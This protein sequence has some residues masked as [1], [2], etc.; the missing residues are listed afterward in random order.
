ML[1]FLRNELTNYG[2]FN[3]PNHIFVQSLIK[4]IP[5]N[6]VPEKMKTIFALSHLSQYASQF[7]RSIQLWD[8]TLVPTNNISFVIADSGANKD[9][10][11]NKI[12][13]CFADGY[14]QIGELVKDYVKNN[15]IEAAEK[16][17]EDSPYEYAI[18]KHYL[19]PIPPVFISITTAPGLIQHVNDIGAL[20]ALS[21]MQYSGEISDE[22]AHNPNALENIKVLAEVYDLGEKEATY[23][24][25]Q[26]FRSAEIKGQPV[27][28]LFVGSPG[29]I[30]Y[31]E[32]T[33]KK[34]HVAFMSKLARRSWFCY[35]PERMS[36]PDF[37][38]LENPI[39]AM[40][41]YEYSI[42]QTAKIAVE[43]VKNEIKILTDYNI[44]LIGT[45]IPTSSDVFD[46]FSIYKR[47]NRE[48]VTASG[49]QESVHALVRAHLQW[50]A[51][52][53]AGALALIECS[54]EVKASHYIT[55]IQYCEMFDSDI[56]KFEKDINKAPHERLS[57]YLR[58][59][60]TEDNFSRISV[61]D[62][63]KLGFS[64]TVSLP[65]LQELVSLCAGYDISGLYTVTE[66]G[67]GIQYD[68]LLISNTIGCSFKPLNTKAL[69]DAITNNA[70]ADTI[71]HIKQQM[72]S[73]AGTGLQYTTGTFAELIDLLSEDY[74]YSPFEFIDGIRSKASLIGATKWVVFDVDKTTTSYEDAHF[75]LDGI[76]HY[77]ALTS[78]KNNAY[79]YR[80]LVE[81]DAP[82]ELSALAWKYFYT[83]LAEQLG[84]TVDLLPQS[85]LFYSYKDRPV[86]SCLE[87]SPVSTRDIVMAAKTKEQ[88]KTT[89]ITTATNSQKIKQLEDP[90]G[91]FW[92]AFECEKGR[93]SV[94]YIRAV[95]HAIDLGADLNYSLS[96]L[97]Q[98]NEYI[99]TP[100]D[101]HTF[102]RLK[103]QVIKMFA[104]NH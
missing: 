48:M 98:I 38:A 14:A 27:S 63:K 71:K 37:S 54:P 75:I 49:A 58:I 57:D 55:A 66:N 62:I 34:F 5:F 50:K 83:D 30:L 59:S 47:Y 40:K 52:K 12:K 91:T 20:P 7:R 42:D 60:V 70:P 1:D 51:L 85:Q 77:V 103:E 43:A 73:T 26:E 35:T 78:D 18:Y 94:T 2:A 8:G 69:N 92:Y 16:A 33:K 23:T 13:K 9:S 22:L 89:V 90:M 79:K 15:A 45:S 61:H 4:A 87:G 100:L 19:K 97:E 84:L 29:H 11:N 39:Q 76:N 101:E 88:N 56:E 80:V 72:A 28:A 3:T 21:G 68:K 99:V 44:Q 24:K 93:R 102:N 6:T 36:E 46:L 53:L 17:G 86:L 95:K 32:A 25:G 10:S 64:N 74:V 82:V 104:E 41:E 67:G 81:L 96:L 31:D 65:K